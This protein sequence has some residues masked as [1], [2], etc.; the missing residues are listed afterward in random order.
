MKRVFSILIGV[1]LLCLVASCGVRQ[2]AMSTMAGVVER[3]MKELEGEEDLWIAKESILPLLKTS[4]LLFAGSNSYKTDAIMAKIY[5]NVAF[6]FFETRFISAPPAEKEVWRRRL[7]RYYEKGASYG[8]EGV[9]RRFGIS[10]RDSFRSFEKK[11]GRA[12]KRDL[13]LLF[14]TAFNMGNLINLKRNDVASIAALPKVEAMLREVIKLKRDFGYGS[15][16]AFMGALAAARPPALGGNYDEAKRLFEEAVAASGG[17]YLMTELIYAKWYAMPTGDTRL[18][19]TLLDDILKKDALAL[20]EQALANQLAKEQAA[21]L[22]SA[23]C[24][25]KEVR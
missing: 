8:M 3:G 12:K 13:E 1:S 9:K 11:I 5:G 23:E 22:R 7:E 4:E 25:G 18:A 10:E 17:K 24:R 20:P 16:L 2:I 21:L 14:W 6:G 15:A 19:C